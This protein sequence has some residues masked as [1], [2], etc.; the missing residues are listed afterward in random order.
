MEFYYCV[1]RKTLA[2]RDLR[3]NVTSNKNKNKKSQTGIPELVK[4]TGNVTTADVQAV[5]V[6]LESFCKKEGRNGCS[7]N[8]SLPSRVKEEVR[9]YAYNNETL[10]IPSYQSIHTQLEM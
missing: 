7:Y 4:A 5:N 6:K 8:T 10:L 9:K 3:S 1:E 2:T